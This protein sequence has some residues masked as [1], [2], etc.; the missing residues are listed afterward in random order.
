MFNFYSAGPVISLNSAAVFFRSNDHCSGRFGGLGHRPHFGGSGDRCTCGC[1]FV[2]RCHSRRNV[3][4][5][6][7]CSSAIQGFNNV[8]IFARLFIWCSGCF[9]P[10]AKSSMEL[11][12]E[13]DPIALARVVRRRRNKVDSSNKK[14][15][16]EQRESVERHDGERVQSASSSGSGD[17]GAGRSLSSVTGLLNDDYYLHPFRHTR[18]SVNKE[19]NFLFQF[20]YFF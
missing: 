2:S 13:E 8:Y 17:S 11:M 9:A 4:F 10:A 19:V 5:R 18:T 16:D 14:S 1:C 15:Q 20:F 12:A 6:A 3:V 7:V